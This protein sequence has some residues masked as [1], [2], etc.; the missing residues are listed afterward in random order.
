MWNRSQINWWASAGKILT[1]LVLTKMIEE[2]IISPTTT[3]F[4][5]DPRYTGKGTYFTSITITNTAAFPFTGSYTF[6]TE[7]FD[8]ETITVSDLIHMNI[9]LTTDFTVLGA[10]FPV[11]CNTRVKIIIWNITN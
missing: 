4:S 8:W 6:T 9:G 5:L 11:L 2:S 3:L 1:G 7:T 10:S